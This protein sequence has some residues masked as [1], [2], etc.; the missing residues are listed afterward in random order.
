MYKTTNGGTLAINDNMQFA[1]DNVQINI[2]PNPVN[3]EAEIDYYVP[4]KTLCLINL[5]ELNGKQIQCVTNEVKDKGKHQI[6]FNTDKFEDGVYFIEL[7]TESKTI[8]KKIIIS[9]N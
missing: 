7:K 9:H 4:L 8:V 2:F 6:R 5:L 1:V 3:V